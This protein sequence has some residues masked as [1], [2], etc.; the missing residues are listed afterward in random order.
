MARLHEY[1]GKQVLA[2]A[3]IAVPRGGAAASAEEA[4]H[5]RLNPNPIARHAP[6]TANRLAANNRPHR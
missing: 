6:R 4:E 1:Q 3:G 5:A 2:G